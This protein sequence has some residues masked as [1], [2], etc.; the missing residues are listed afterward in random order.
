MHPS[1]Y[2]R[3]PGRLERIGQLLL[4]LA[5]FCTAWATLA[6]TEDDFESFGE[7]DTFE[8]APLEEPISL[9][10]WFK[11]SFLDLPE[12]LEEAIS[13]GKTGLMVYLGQKY[14]AYC[15]K[16]LHDN[17]DKL[18]IL[19][20][21]QKHF[22]A[23]GI[24]IHGQR[25]VTN[26]KA[27]EWTERSFAVEQDVDFTPTLI[28]YDKDK[29]EA[30]R[31]TGYYPPYKFRA[32]L[33]YVAAGYYL[34]EDFRTYL[35]RADV[36]LVFDA[37]DMNY[38]D[39]FSP[40]PHALDRSRWLG[41]RPL[42]VFFEQANCHACDVLHTGPLDEADIRQR[43]KQLDLTQLDMWSDTPVITPAGERTTAKQWADQL[44]LFYT[45]T[46]VFFDEQGGEILRVDSV[47]QFY[48]LRNVLDYILS[49]AYRQ[50]PTF[51]Q[52]RSAQGR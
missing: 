42:A 4:L 3:K 27:M 22:D 41:Q 30:L 48:R 21:T 18:D 52:W 40:P 16:L 34:K 33:E 19:A 28:F 32:A 51:Q 38:Q 24:D 8:D 1:R 10:A 35:A 2:L 45:P 46:L 47:V 14:C 6:Q 15:K 7:L 49:G 11:L 23:I 44:G 5:T 43:I 12:D 37:G 25:V 17:F 13:A 29:H 20:Y 36:P 50:Y 9:P 26:L 39:F 31:L